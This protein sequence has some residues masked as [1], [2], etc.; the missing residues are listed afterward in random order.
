M[1]LFISP[2]GDKPAAPQAFLNNGLGANPAI[3]VVGPY[4]GGNGVIIDS[5]LISE[6]PIGSNPGQNTP[7]TISAIATQTINEDTATGAILFTIGDAETSAAS[8]L[9]DASS[10][11]P[12]LAPRA[13]I[14]LGGSGANRTVTVMPL[15]DQFGSANITLLVTD[16]ENTNSTTFTLVVNPMPE[17][18]LVAWADPAPVFFGTPLGAA[19]FNATANV[20]GTLTY[21]PA[22]GTL[23]PV[24]NG[25]PLTVT[26]T[27]ADAIN[28]TTVTLSLPINVLPWSH[29]DVGSVALAGDA[30]LAGTT[31]TISGSGVDIWDY[32]DGFQFAY[33]P[34]TGDGEI[35]AR[36]TGIANTDPW[37]K[38]GVMFRESLATGSRHAFM[39]ITPGNGSSF[40]RRIATDSFSYHTTP[41]DFATA[42]YWVRLIRTGDQFYGYI[43]ADGVTWYFTGADTVPMSATLFVGLAVTA[44]NNTVLS[45]GTFTDIQ[46]RIPAPAPQIAITA[47]ASGSLLTT[48]VAATIDT[49]VNLNGASISK[50]QFFD[51]GQFLG[52]DAT[53]PYSLGWNGVA[54]GS[55]TLTALAFYSG[56]LV[57]Q[58]PSAVVS[59]ISPIA[60]P[61]QH[62]DVGAVGFA[63]DATSDSGNF[64]ITG[65]G[66]DIWDAADGFH[67][68]QQPWTGNGEIIARVTG[69]ANTDPWAKVGVMFRETLA[70]GSRHA[71][72]AITPGNGSAFQRRLVANEFSLHTPGPVV[73]APY[74]VRLMRV[75]DLFSGY[76][77]PDG[78]TWTLVGTENVPMSATLYAGLAVTAHN[79]GV[80]NTSTI[81]NVEI[82][83]PRPEIALA[84]PLNGTVFSSP[85]NI[86]IAANVVSNGNAIA[87]VQFFGN[88]LLVGEAITPP[89]TATWSAAPSGTH[90]LTARTFTTG[91]IIVTSAPI[92]VTVLEPIPAPWQHQ[93]VGAVGF[94]GSAAHT[95]GAFTIGGSGVDI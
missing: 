53:A 58:S 85:A 89:Y 20:P 37:A 50:V 74:W 95:N 76:I 11:N 46:T 34:W 86:A 27:P 5:L 57:S 4:S 68:V 79:N 93:D 41:G 75:G 44:H 56:G 45:T 54:L 67:F 15:P 13:S 47:P 40:Q 26:F 90:A 71:F 42:P 59:V 14:V 30:A 7:P 52:E 8:L 60:A 24:G 70:T 39:C 31:Y 28:Y 22:V 83:V 82:R 12:A 23:L 92:T 55:H 10:S 64:T 6:N 80:L 17:T 88:S 19:Q 25:Q 32:A 16:G 66:T 29:Q 3:F 18:P 51:N 43:S 94:A 48:P 33:R 38:A 62:Q 84:S 78:A 72:M 69:L 1:R 35:I 73:I 77:S 49:S 91:G 81:S 65:S 9:L 63:G 87:R 36:V 2:T 21:S 61:W